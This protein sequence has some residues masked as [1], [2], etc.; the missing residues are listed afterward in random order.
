MANFEYAAT[1]QLAKVP[2]DVVALR[3][4]WSLARVL[5][6][7][8]QCVVVIAGAYKGKLMEYMMLYHPC[9]S[10]YGFEPQPW[11]YDIA[12]A[13][14]APYAA[15]HVHPWGIALADVSNLPM[16]EWGTDGCSMMTGDRDTGYG[17]FKEV[18]GEFQKII[19]HEERA[20]D[21]CILNMEGYEFLL[22][23]G[24]LRQ[25]HIAS[26]VRRFAVQFHLQYAQPAQYGATLYALDQHYQHNFGYFL[27]SWGLWSDVRLHENTH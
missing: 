24:L 22:L 5:H 25:A 20:I 14:V 16:G 12:T 4:E 26:M 2:E 27:P 7:P 17:Q 23:E 10:V 19:Q 9:K 11:A 21:L 15:C 1:G 8:E 18:L 6:L 13:R 3:D